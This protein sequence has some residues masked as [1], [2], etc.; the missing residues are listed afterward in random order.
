MQFF[1][2]PLKHGTVSLEPVAFEF[3]LSKSSAATDDGFKKGT[4]NK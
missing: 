1:L 2:D 4:T 3:E